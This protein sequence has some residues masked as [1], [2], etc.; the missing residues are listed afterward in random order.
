MTV[1]DTITEAA[2]EAAAAETEK[3]EALEA[4]AT[5]QAAATLTNAA[6]V[7]VATAE[8]AGELAKVE[9][10][11]ALNEKE[12][13]ISW[14]KNQ[15]TAQATAQAEL[16]QKFNSLSEG[17]PQM[18]EQNRAQTL[19]DIKTLLAPPPQTLPQEA[20]VEVLDAP[21][22]GQ[23]ENHETQPKPQNGQQAETPKRHVKNPNNWF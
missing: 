10:A 13:D 21:A 12:D 14:L 9:A 11:K 22:D 3:E 16:H 1:E 8:A 23:K 6:A 15:S 20:V 18:L 19:E 4:Q 2:L 17:L 7:A 5:A